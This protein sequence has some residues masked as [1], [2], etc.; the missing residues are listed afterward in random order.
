MKS[1]LKSFANKTQIKK[2]IDRIKAV[3]D[4]YGISEKLTM[5]VIQSLEGA[6]PEYLCNILKKPFYTDKEL[7]KIEKCLTC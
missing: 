5:K 1:A 7:L 6:E 3:G 4:L 2:H